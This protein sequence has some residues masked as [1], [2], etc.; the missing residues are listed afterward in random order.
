MKKENYV[1]KCNEDNF[2]I[3]KIIELEEKNEYLLNRLEK[4]E[5]YLFFLGEFKNE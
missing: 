5:N 2:Y 3:Q 4:V 1:C